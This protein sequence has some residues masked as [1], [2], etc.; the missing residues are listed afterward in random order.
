MDWLELHKQDAMIVTC[1]FSNICM[2]VSFQKK[3]MASIN[4]LLATD[5]SVCGNFSAL[6]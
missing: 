6:N 4:H 3:I 1:L 5:F 2:A